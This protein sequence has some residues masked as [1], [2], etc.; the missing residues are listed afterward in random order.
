[1]NFDD[2][3]DAWAGD[4]TDVP[5][6][7]VRDIPLKKVGS[8]LAGIRGNMRREFIA[9]A[10]AYVAT[11][12]FFLL[13]CKTAFAVYM[14]S[15]IIFILL[16]QSGYY[17]FR[18]YLFYKA[19]GRY[20]LSV[21]RSI[22]K[23]IYELELNIQIYKTYNFCAMPLAILATIAIIAGDSITLLPGHISSGILVKPVSLLW[24]FL[25]LGVSQAITVFFLN[26][27]IR[28]QYGRYLADLKAVVYE[29]ETDEM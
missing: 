13:F 22:R 11:I 26:L 8:S 7:P 16:M 29:L 17:F 27:H 10:A 21:V 15:V 2:L 24:V 25:I 1:M 20:D 18:F 19:S 5:P 6:L 9:H 12:I 14:G 4:M 3:K 23:I 28:L